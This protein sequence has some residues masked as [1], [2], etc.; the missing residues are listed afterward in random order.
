MRQFLYDIVII[1]AGPAG[2][3]AALQAQD[4]GLK[5][6][7]I[8]KDRFPRPKV[9]GGGIVRRSLN[10]LPYN[11]SPVVSQ[12]FDNVF[13]RFHQFKFEH[14]IKRAYPVIQTVSREDF[15]DF[16]LK[17]VNL[18]SVEIRRETSLEN[19]S[20]GD[21]LT[22]KLSQGEVKTRFLIVA[23]GAHSKTAH[24]LGMKEDRTFATALE[25]EI[26]D[27]YAQSKLSDNLRFDIGIPPNGYGWVFPKSGYYSIGIGR[28]SPRKGK[29]NLRYYLNN[30]F[31][32]LG[33]DTPH[34]GQT[35]GAVI[36]VS[37]RKCFSLPRILFTGDAAGFADPIVAEGISYALLSGQLAVRSILEGQ[38][39]P[40]KTN[41]V[42]RN[43][44]QSQILKYH[45]V[46]R[47]CARIL[48]EHP[49]ITSLVFKFRG[50]YLAEEYTNI[51]VGDNRLPAGLLSFLK[52]TY[53][54]LR[55][56]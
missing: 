34:P 53:Y 22:L 4:T 48:Y 20:N 44:I 38:L 51:Y 37:A 50:K 18:S 14:E 40:V 30:Y 16:L 2:I 17:Q 6:L 1:G 35:H 15:D 45:R 52:S 13:I 47:F 46:G 21:F 32:F 8:E 12:S 56:R 41:L 49:R 55:G 43:K 5:T 7:L 24:L 39:D 33:L 54:T 9:C 26:D 23:D 3:S 29:I 19:V 27:H 36:P 31:S 42:Y 11:I 10:K 25:C 28:F